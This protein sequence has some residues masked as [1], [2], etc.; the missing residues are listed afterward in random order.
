[1]PGSEILHV[2]LLSHAT[3]ETAW[4]IWERI[5][6]QFPGIK[7]QEH[8]RPNIR[9]PQQIIDVMRSASATR[10]I[11]FHS[12]VDLSL[13]ELVH[14]AALESGV[15]DVDILGLGIAAVARLQGK[16][17]SRKVGH[18]DNPNFISAVNFVED[19]D[20]G[21]L[22]EE[23]HLAHVVVLGLSRTSKTP[24]SMMLARHGIHAAN[25]PIVPGRPLPREL[26][27]VDPQRVFVLYKTPE[28]LA[29]VRKTRLKHL[30]NIE[31]NDDYA[32][33]NT[34]REEV[35]AS[36]RIQAA[37]PGWTQVDTT[38]SSAE[39]AAADILAHYLE[40]FPAAA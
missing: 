18:R 10:S 26:E 7:V 37:H 29:A 19:H 36:L 5:R 6:A 13:Q 8:W 1:M 30:G 27:G 22:P 12:L 16:A 39:D 35:L 2:Y 20:D 14:V 31:T 38:R 32:D 9:K 28:R 24:V 34:V 3:G 11:V 33:L 40:R 17:P 15:D 23:L 21:L 4:R 25:V